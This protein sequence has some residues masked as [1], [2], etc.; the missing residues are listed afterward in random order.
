MT[1]NLTIRIDQELKTKANELFDSLGMNL[2][3]AINVFLRHAVE[4]EGFPF[5]I[6][7]RTANPATISAIE[8]AKVLMEDSSAHLYENAD[9]LIAA[10]EHK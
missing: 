5:A 9:A 8:E 7:R 4:M 1:A 6:R 2:S 10:L 3:T